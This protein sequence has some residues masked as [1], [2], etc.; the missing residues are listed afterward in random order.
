MTYP[1]DI[2][3]SNGRFTCPYADN[4]TA[5]GMYF[6]RDMCGLGVGDEFDDPYIPEDE[7]EITAE[8]LAEYQGRYRS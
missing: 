4:D 3:D 2:K 6:C 5:T 8:D 7:D 1:C